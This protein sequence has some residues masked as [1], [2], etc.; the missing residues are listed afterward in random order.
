MRSVHFSNLNSIPNTSAF[1]LP[2]TRT[3]NNGTPHDPGQETQT[4]FEFVGFVVAMNLARSVKPLTSGGIAIHLKYE[5]IMLLS[6]DPLHIVEVMIFQE[7]YRQRHTTPL[8][9][10]RE[11]L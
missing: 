10:L 6:M 3:G 4:S 8:E 7:C 1:Q 9:L 11:L 5:A 2:G